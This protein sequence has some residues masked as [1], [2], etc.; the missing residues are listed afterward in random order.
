MVAF[1]GGVVLAYISLAGSYPPARTLPPTQDTSRRDGRVE[2]AA[3]L[4]DRSGGRGGVGGAGGGG[5]KDLL[6]DGDQVGMGRLAGTAEEIER[7]TELSRTQLLQEKLWDYPKALGEG[8]AG[9]GEGGWIVGRGGVGGQG[10]R[11]L[12]GYTGG[13]GGGEGR[14]GGGREGGVG[15]GGGDGNSCGGGSRY[16]ARL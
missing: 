6:R 16:V 1:K 12:A 3:R 14:R 4:G 15:G 8:G 5:G 13:E 10:K 2:G 9:E 11:S 7:L